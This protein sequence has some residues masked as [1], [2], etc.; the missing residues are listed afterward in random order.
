MLGSLLRPR[1]MV[2][3]SF[4]EELRHFSNA[5]REDAAPQ[6]SS[7][8]CCLFKGTLITTTFPLENERVSVA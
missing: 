3:F 7:L 5:K 8:A 1:S 6:S 4:G 2:L